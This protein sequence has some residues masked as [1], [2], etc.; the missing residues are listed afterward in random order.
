MV[1]MRHV[2]STAAPPVRP[3]VLVRGTL[4]DRP[5]GATLAAIGLSGRTGQLTLRARSGKHHQLAFSNGIVVGATSPAA[6]DS[7]AR[8]ALAN[9]LVSASQ[10][11]TLTRELGRVRAEDVE[12]FAD[13]TGLPPAQRQLLKRRVII[14]RTAR[15]FAIDAGDYTVD[16]E[17]TIPVLLGVEVDVR[18]AIYVGI[19]KHLAQDRLT[20]DLRQLGTRFVLRPEVVAELAR[21]ELGDAEQP[22]LE[23]LREGT[24]VPELE[25][26]RREIDPRMAEAVLCTLAAC[27]ALIAAPGGE[28]LA[29]VPTPQDMSIP[30]APT[31]SELM[32]T[33]V[34]TPR[35]PTMSCVPMLIREDPRPRTP[36]TSPPVALPARAR[37]VTKHR[38][39]TDPFLELQATSQRPNPLSFTQIKRLIASR[40][41]LLDKGVDHFEFLG[42]PFGAP[43]PA[44]RTAYLELARYLRP[45]RLKELGYEDK[46]HDARS[47]YAQIV[48]AHTVLTDPDRRVA[49]LATLCRK[50]S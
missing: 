9:Q 50:T 19:R 26:S 13:A 31:P 11:A 49:Y 7:V 2:H 32:M 15:T 46:H 37:A 22:V 14:E 27:D 4:A 38:A 47:V 16:D 28:L 17:I 23:A 6:A 42:I 45:E 18:A 34:P 48:I 25:A 3:T 43:I 44:V 29:R 8:I 35:E 24:S 30:R 41:A 39:L 10:V 12:K 1:T 20:L 33:R 40:A 21:F 5:W 36:T